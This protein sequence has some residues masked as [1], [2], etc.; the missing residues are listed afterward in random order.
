MP[1]FNTPEPISVIVELG[2]G[3]LRIEASDRSDTV[4]EVRPSDPAKRSDVNAAENARVEYADGRL[5]V[6]AAKGWRQYTPRGGGE[7]IAVQINLPAGSEVRADAGVA[8]FHCTGRLGTCRLTTG[9]GDLE[10]EET[11]GSTRF[12][13]GIG[14]IT[15]GRALGHVE[16]TTGSG[17][18]RIESVDG[19]AVVKNSNGSTWIGEIVGDLRANA[20]NGTIVVDQA[21]ATVTAKT[22]N[23]DVR[24]GE[25]GNGAIVAETA[26]GKIDIGIRPGTA[27]WLDLDTRFGN[28]HNDLDAVARPEAGEA[29]VEVRAHT[30]F[31]DVTVRHAYDDGP[32]GRLTLAPH[33]LGR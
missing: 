24:L 9:M 3:D 20:A 6:K 13:T 32:G 17:A 31:G 16:V 4:V 18:V 12:K 2:V 14:D 8:A 23:G 28:V 26:R 33:R 21:G 30:S 1:T 19:T 29:T 27:A 11:G 10:I 7:S 25:V 5:S 15:V 22:A